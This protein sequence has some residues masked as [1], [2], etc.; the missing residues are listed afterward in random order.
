[1]PNISPPNLLTL[2]RQ[3]APNIALEHLSLHTPNGE[4][5]LIQ[6]L[7]LHLTVGDT[8]LIMGPRG[9]GK[10]SLLRAIAGLWHTGSGTIVT[11]TADQILF[12]PQRPYLMAGTLRQ[13]LLYPHLDTAVT[14]DHM[15]QVLTQVNL[16]SLLSCWGG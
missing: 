9:V 3:T 14:D 4:R 13:Q 12:L 5:T 11:P 2:T 10:S 15:V 7:S 8:L 1:M 16:A 6:D